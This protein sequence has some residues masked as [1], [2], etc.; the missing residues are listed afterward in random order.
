MNLSKISDSIISLPFFF[1]IQDLLPFLD[2]GPNEQH[3]FLPQKRPRVAH[4]SAIVDI[5]GESEDG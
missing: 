4:D 2:K 5:A 1:L 3:A